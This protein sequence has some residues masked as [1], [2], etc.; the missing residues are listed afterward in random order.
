MTARALSVRPASMSELDVVLGLLKER[1]DW[2]R[3][4]GSDQWSAWETWRAKIQPALER[5]HVWLLLDGS[6]PIGTVSVEFQGDHDFWSGDERA[7][8][9]AYL[10]KLAIRLDHAGHELGALLTSWVRDYA[11]RRGCR[12]VRL[13]AWKTNDRLHA[14]YA[15]RGWKYVRTVDNPGRNSGALF[16]LPVAAM[17]RPQRGRLRDDFPVVVLQP[18]QGGPGATEP[19]PAGNWHPHHVHRGGMKVQYDALQRPRSAEF[20]DFMRYRLRKAESVWLLEG[21]DQHFTDWRRHGVV[22]ETNLQLSDD[23]KYVLTHQDR[24]DDC[25]MVVV[26]EPPELA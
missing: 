18:T 11:Y 5:G 21:V 12:Y 15:S 25:R 19:D 16:Q 24:E 8:P 26:S 13:D 1:I 4:Q 10:S 14:Y 23:A 7:E 22:L 17:A 9:A 6:D 20:I 3:A 2:L